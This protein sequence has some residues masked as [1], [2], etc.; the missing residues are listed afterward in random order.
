MVTRGTRRWPLLSRATRSYSWYKHMKLVVS[1]TASCGIYFHYRG[2]LSCLY[3]A[4]SYLECRWCFCWSFWI[5][6]H[7][8]RRPR[9]LRPG[10]TMHW[11]WLSGGNSVHTWLSKK[12]SKGQS[13]TMWYSTPGTCRTSGTGRGSARARWPWPFRTSSF[14][15]TMTMAVCV[16]L[17][18]NKKRVDSVRG[19]HW[20]LPEIMMN[21]FSDY[22]PF[23]YGLVR[24]GLWDRMRGL[25]GRNQ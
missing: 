24:G 12:A 2:S 10:A 14:L 13:Y 15:C 20:K 5:T 18:M 17:K 9:G 11:S 22:P 23:H 1:T 16:T 21:N 8:W 3:V 6:S 25:E 19:I 7:G 4:R